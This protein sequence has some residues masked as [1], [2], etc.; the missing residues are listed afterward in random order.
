MTQANIVVIRERIPLIFYVCTSL[1]CYYYFESY[2][3]SCHGL[4]RTNW[5]L[6]N[7]SILNIWI[8]T[9]YDQYDIIWHYQSQIIIQFQYDSSHLQNLRQ[10]C[11]CSSLCTYRPENRRRIDN[12]VIYVCVVYLWWVNI[13]SLI[14]IIIIIVRHSLATRHRCCLPRTAAADTTCPHQSLRSGAIWTGSHCT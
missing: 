10:S 3:N 4:L 12:I 9:Y 8:H 1:L 13:S 5:F 7:V 11:W 6:H 14:I 2:L